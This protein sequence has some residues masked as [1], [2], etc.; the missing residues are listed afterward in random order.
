MLRYFL[1]IF[2]KKEFIIYNIENIH[3]INCNIILTKLYEKHYML[4]LFIKIIRIELFVLPQCYY[5]SFS[6][7]VLWIGKN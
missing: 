4:D 1:N 3:I 5:F 7:I 6:T 2:N